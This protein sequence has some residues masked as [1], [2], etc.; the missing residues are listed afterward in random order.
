MTKGN[1]KIFI[2]LDGLFIIF[3]LF[4]F[5]LLTGLEY[6][7]SQHEKY[8]QQNWIKIEATVTYYSGGEISI[9][10]YT[11]T[12]DGV[13]YTGRDRSDYREIGEVIEIYINPNDAS[14]SEIVFYIMNG[15]GFFLRIAAVL[16]II[17]ET[18]I[19]III[20]KYK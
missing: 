6:N 7:L 5:F 4:I 20:I 16:A 11:Y 19:L 13:T 8:I 2:L 9:A 10:D 3:S 14:Q 18:V 15:Y 12:I 17:I 1:K